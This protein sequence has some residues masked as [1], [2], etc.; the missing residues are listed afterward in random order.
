[1]ELFGLVTDMAYPDLP[2]SEALRRVALDPFFSVAEVP[3]SSEV[4]EVAETSGLVL[5]YCAQPAVLDEGADLGA[6]DEGKRRRAVEV[7]G[8]HIER[9]GRMGA[10]RLVVM[11]GPDPGEGGR[12]EARRQL[13]RS[14]REVCDRAWDYGIEVVLETFDRDVDKRSLLG[15]TE[16]AVEVVEAVNR[17]NLGLLLDLSHLPLLR[18]D[19]WY[20]VQIA[21]ELLFHVHVGNC[22]TEPSSP[23]YGDKHPRFGVDGGANGVEDVEDFIRALHDVGFFEG[24]LP[25]VSIEVRPLPGEDPELVLAGS[26]RLLTEALRRARG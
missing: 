2:P 18:E 13:V 4:R 21:G 5:T 24:E 19:P 16:E 8:R 20:A 22:V 14:L 23:L 6:S 26:K 15:P 25:I 7:I 11:S 10:K 9:A 1:M 17:A 12:R 3:S